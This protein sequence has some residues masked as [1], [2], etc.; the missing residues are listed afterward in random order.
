MALNFYDRMAFNKASCYNY[1]CRIYILGK[2]KAKLL[3]GDLVQVRYIEKIIKNFQLGNA[4]KILR[5][6]QEHPKN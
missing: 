5:L 3:R 4:I 6:P 2:K 1:E